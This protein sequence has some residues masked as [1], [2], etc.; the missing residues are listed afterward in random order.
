MLTGLARIKLFSCENE[1]GVYNDECKRA[2]KWICDYIVN[3]CSRPPQSH[4][5]DM[6]STIVAAYQC[7]TVWF[8]EHYYL[9]QDKECISMLLEVI[10]LGISGSKSKSKIKIIFKDE[11]ELKPASMRVRDSAETLLSCLMNHFCQTDPCP[12]ETMFG[13][14]SFDESSLLKHLGYGSSSHDDSYKKFKYFFS[15]NFLLLSVLNNTPSGMSAC[16]LRSP[17]GKF[18]WSMKFQV[19][20]QK[21]IVTNYI[22]KIPRPVP[23]NNNRAVNNIVPHNFPDSV[24][25]VFLSKL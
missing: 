24:E 19:F 22:E 15:D 5:K 17:F 13:S 3:Q 16:I 23:F 2:A 7:L 10:E 4:S 14:I 20:P 18:C 11:K 12:T 21:T 1:R 6:H 8:Q 25:K 9:L